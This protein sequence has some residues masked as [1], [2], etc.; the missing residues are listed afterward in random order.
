MLSPMEQE[1]L[2][3]CLS[4]GVEW[5]AHLAEQCRR[6]DAATDDLSTARLRAGKRRENEMY[7]AMNR[8]KVRDGSEQ[9]FEAV[10]KNRKSTL[11]E[12]PG[13]QSFHLLRGPHNEAEGYHL[14]ASHTVWRS[15]ADF[16]A[17]TR[18]QNFRDAH[19][20]AGESRVQYLGHPQFEGFVAVEGA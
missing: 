14:Y 10:W 7:V 3:C 9:D 11:D 15:E 19:R 18:S 4:H 17:W 16:L 20:N 13:F 5:P 6:E 8:F 12:M 1:M 2:Q